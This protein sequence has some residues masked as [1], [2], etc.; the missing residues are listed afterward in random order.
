MRIAELLDPGCSFGPIEDLDVSQ[1]LEPRLP[2]VIDQYQ[3]HAVVRHQVPGADV[4]LVTAKIRESDGSL[5]DHFQEALRTAAVLYIGP[6]VFADTRH[7]EAVA[8]GKELDLGRADGIRREARRLS[9]RILPAG[10][11]A[12]LQRRD[13]GGKN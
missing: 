9:S 10:A 8:F 12:L 4:L 5:V 13:G 11:G 3:R 1:N 7:I 2:R 6:A